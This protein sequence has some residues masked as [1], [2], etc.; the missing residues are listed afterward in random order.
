M[1]SLINQIDMNNLPEHIAIIMDGNGRWAK[2]RLL[3]KKMGHSAGADALERVTRCANKLGVKHITVYAFSTENWK[4]DNEEIKG[5]MD[6]LRDYLDNYVKRYAK[7]NIRIDVIGD[8]SALDE[9]IQE[10]I[11]KVKADSIDRT[12]LNLHIA[13]N[14][15]GR[16][17]ILRAVKSI[18][19][20]VSKGEL[21][22]GDII[23]DLISKNLDTADY[24]DPEFVIRTS[25]E[26]RLS[27][28][29]LWQVAYSEF[30]FNRKLWP[31][32]G[33]EDFYSDICYYQTKDRRFGG[34]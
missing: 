5:I 7:D 34:R 27:N 1:E 10:K 25:G 21:E 28:F 23:E 12:G 8:M 29:L 30:V 3:P 24:P 4:R 20:Q 19:S 9:D 16:D 6:I 14:Y 33:E 11:V 32:Y 2:K 18:S 22:A 17:D 31:D 26:E 13:L 15:G